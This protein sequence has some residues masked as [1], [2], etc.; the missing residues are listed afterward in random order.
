MGISLERLPTFLAW[1]GL[2]TSFIFLI[3]NLNTIPISLFLG[4]DIEYPRFRKLFYVSVAIF[5]IINIGMFI[6]SNMLW[7]KIKNNDVVGM[8]TFVKIGCYIMAGL[9]ILA[10]TAAIGIFS[11]FV[12]VFSFLTEGD[13]KIIAISVLAICI[14]ISVIFIIFISLMIHGV[15]KMKACLVNIY[16]VFRITVFIIYTILVLTLIL[17]ALVKFADW[18]RLILPVVLANMFLL[19]S[20]LYIFSAGFSVLQYNIML[21][22][23]NTEEKTIKLQTFRQIDYL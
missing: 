7:R 23:L 9:E 5:T 13:I 8:K 1:T 19:S 6:Y 14:L 10:S 17:L 3:G 16:I 20:F 11:V 21:G 18:Y 12:F 2:V 4:W 22:L 15:R